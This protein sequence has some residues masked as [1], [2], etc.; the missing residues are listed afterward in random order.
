MPKRSAT[1]EGGDVPNASRSRLGRGFDSVSFVI[2]AAGAVVSLLMLAEA[3]H[4]LWAGVGHGLDITDEGLY[5]RSADTLGPDYAYAGFS[6]AYLHPLFRLAGYDVATFRALGIILLGVSGLVLSYGFRRALASNLAT[7]PGDSHVVDTMTR[8][9]LDVAIV[10]GA[11]TYYSLFLLTPSYNWLT[12]VGVLVC[13]AGALALLGPERGSRRDL[14]DPALVAFGSF[15]ALMGRPTAGVGLWVIGVTLL[16]AASARPFRRRLFALGVLTAVTFAVGVFHLVFVTGWSDSLDIARRTAYFAQND[17]GGH[18][19]RS[20]GTS[21]VRQL[22]LIGPGVS[23]QV[24]VLPLLGFSVLFAGWAPA[25]LRGAVA[26]AL[27]AASVAVVAWRVWAVGGFA[28]AHDAV[29]LLPFAGFA[30]LLTA[31][32][33][34]ASAVALQWLSGPRAAR[35]DVL[36]RAARFLAAGAFFVFSAGLYTFSS[37]N[38]VVY[39]L[40]GGFGILAIAT[41]LLVTSG[42]GRAALPVTAATMAAVCGVAAICTISGG[43]AAPYRMAPMAASTVP[44]R[45]SDRGAILNLSPASAEALTTMRSKALSGG[46]RAG[47]PLIDLTPFHPGIGYLLNARPPTT[48][49][50][51]RSPQVMRW[52]LRQQDE[53]VFH[54]AWLLT[55]SSTTPR[56]LAVIGVLDRSFP[57][58][59]QR[60]AAVSYPPDPLPLELWRPRTP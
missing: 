38:G 32:I 37:N 49:L 58:D 52:A 54:D 13:G 31:A 16:L 20:L 21:T 46:W 19:L 59:Y 29:L 45:V 26:G 8:V 14:A 57:V 4:R 56:Q 24:G 60:V 42:L 51:G 10:C 7:V 55:Q 15:L 3:L 12:L 34:F 53:A 35:G 17:V 2:A 44:T 18:D 23:A 28:G 36:V 5:L 22:A 1:A 27:G 43:A 9:C 41:I 6:G 39:Q 30:L 47:M 48:I 40:W 50:I 33:V 25:R 11:E